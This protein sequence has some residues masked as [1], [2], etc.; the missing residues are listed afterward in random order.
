MAQPLRAR[1]SVVQSLFRV[2]E[3]LPR[4][5]SERVLTRL[6]AI[7]PV[8]SIQ[9]APAISWVEETTFLAVLERVHQELGDEEYV[10]MIHQACLVML[11]TGVVRAARAAADLFMKPSFSGYARW[12][13]RIWSLSFQGLVLDYG[14]A[15]SDEI[16][17]HLSNPPGGRFTKPV[18]LGAAGVVQAVYSL[19]KAP[20]KVAVAPYQDTDKQ[21]I[22]RL[23]RPARP[24]VSAMP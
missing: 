10:E 20:G 12:A 7:V 17:M 16:R 1:A 9:R 18:V 3:H 21:V 5:R 19:W 11:K 23:K 22:L 8:E 2:L 15:D 6:R 24:D 14:G 13:A 4:A